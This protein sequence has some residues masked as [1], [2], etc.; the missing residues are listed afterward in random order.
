MTNNTEIQTFQL[1]PAILFEII[2]AQAGSPQKALLETVMTAIDAGATK[3]DITV[4]CKGFTVI[5]DGKGF[6]VGDEGRKAIEA[7]FKTFGT[8]H[9]EGDARYGKFRMGRGQI[10]AFGT[11]VWRTGTFQMSVDIKNKGADYELKSELEPVVGCTITESFYEPLSV[12]E[13]GTLTRELEKMVAFAEIPITINKKVV[14]KLPSSAKWD[15]ETDEAY[16]KFQKTGMLSVYN[17]GVLVFEHHASKYGTG[18]TIVSKQR[19]TV[20]FARND[21]LLSKCA[22]WRKTLK[23]IQKQAGRE[24]T[25]KKTLTEIDRQFIANQMLAGDYQKHA[26][27]K[28]I[29]DVLGRH[30]KLDVLFSQYR[31]PGITVAP[32][33]HDHK[34]ERIHSTKSAFVLAPETL[35]RF[36]CATLEELQVKLAA[37]RHYDSKIKS[38]DFEELAAFH[39]ADF[40][41]IG[42]TRLA[43]TLPVLVPMTTTWSSTN[44]FMT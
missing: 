4:T 41:T 38:L 18:G 36:G 23:V 11:N 2:N 15:E 43:M 44:A 40:R 7:F 39:T 19:L 42:Y 10:M 29:T 21:I 25:K 5:D 3:C 1:H 22:V 24:I 13:F 16:F 26:Q 12:A 37:V 9:E 34:G 31:Y 6:G 35:E 30:H 14:S 27:A 20:N 8:P 33:V 32:T 28:V 17:L